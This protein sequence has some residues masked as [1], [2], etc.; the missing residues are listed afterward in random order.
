MIIL[1]H[2]ITE[3]QADL[4]RKWKI[5]FR[6]IGVEVGRPEWEDRQEILRYLHQAK[7]ATFFSRDFDF[8]NAELCHSNYALVTIAAPNKETASFIRRFLRHPKFKTKATRCGKVIRLSSRV[9]SWWEIGNEQQQ[10]M[11]W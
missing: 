3:D 5:R 6:K 4:L 7:Q 10:D 2:N 1:D 9:I 8:F 11:I